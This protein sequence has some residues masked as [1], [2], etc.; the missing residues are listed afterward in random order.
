MELREKI[1]TSFLL[2]LMLVY[3]RRKHSWHTDLWIKGNNLSSDVVD[4]EFQFSYSEL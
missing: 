4:A 3:L 2:K 1:T